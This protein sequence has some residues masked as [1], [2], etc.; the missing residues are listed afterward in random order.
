M[1]SYCW[2]IVNQ[3][4]DLHGCL[5]RGGQHHHI[6]SIKGSATEWNNKTW[7][8]TRQALVA[9]KGWVATSWDGG[10]GHEWGGAAPTSFE[11]DSVQGT[12]EWP[13]WRQW[14]WLG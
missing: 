2:G 7:S 13:V 10:S 12:D 5:G 8:K 14:W 9:G 6:D 11:W 4:V 1:A 3:C